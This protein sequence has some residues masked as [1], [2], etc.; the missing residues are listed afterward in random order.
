MPFEWHRYRLVQLLDDIIEQMEKE[1]AYRCFH[2]DGQ[3]IVLEDYLAIRPYMRERLFRLIEAD[4][5]QVGPWYVLQD[6]YLISDEANVRNMLIGLALCREWGVEP[7]MTGY[8]PDS[9]GNVSQ[10]PQILNGFSIHTAVFGRGGRDRAEINWQSED[11]S[12]VAA[13]WLAGWYHNALELPTD[14]EASRMRVQKLCQQAET[15]S[16]LDDHVGMNG[17]DHEPL[18]KNLTQALKTA[19]EVSGPDVQFVHSSLK[20]FLPILLANRERYPVVSGELAGQDGHG[21]NLLI[22]TASS[23]IYL[24]QWNHLVQTA[25]ERRAEPL[26]ALAS[27]YG[28]ACDR[29]FLRYAWKKLLENHAHDSICGCSVDA[30]HRQMVARFESAGQL[31][32][33][34]AQEALSHLTARVDTREV[35]GYP[36]TVWNTAVFATDGV[37]EAVVDVPEGAMGD[38]RLLDAEGQEIPCTLIWEPHTFTYTLPQDA[39]RVV[40]YVDRCRVRFAARQVP[41]MGCALYTLVPGA[42]AEAETL[43]YTDNQM[44]NRWLRVQIG[45]DGALSVTD[46]TTGITMDGL[47]VYEDTPDVGD[48][49]MFAAGGAPVTTAGV[50]AQVTFVGAT[51]GEAAFCIRQQLTV[52]AGYNRKAGH[53]LED[54]RVVTLCT[55]VSIT[56]VSRSVEIRTEIDNTAGNHR[57]CAL[58]PNSIRTDK[59]YANGQFDIVERNIHTGPQ[60]KNPTN[61][62]RMQAF[63]ELRDERQA[64]VVAGQALHE[65]EV[66]RDGSNTLSLTILRAVDELGDWGV[67]PTPEAQC[68]GTC[69]AEYTV[70]VGAAA[71]HCR[72]EREALTYYSGPLFAAQVPAGQTG[73]LR[74]GVGLLAV[75]GEGIWSTAFKCAETGDGLVLRLYNTQSCAAE[76]TLT[77]DERVTGVYAANL[78]EETAGED[79]LAEGRATL[80]FRPKEIR[81]VVLT[82]KA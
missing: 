19:N 42:P 36:L 63:V 38:Y 62:Q 78:A 59:V 43:C 74:P 70:Q 73:D 75:D 25:L 14:A 49:Y 47:N 27:L 39:F 10:I 28:K 1:P 57:L 54:P 76:A 64:L 22:G 79:L 18:Q 65:Y 3:M 26:T 5:I 29:D 11:G 71:E 60:W 2:L 80:T 56:A 58:F 13:L 6:E 24:K 40:T 81:T 32:E 16:C 34:V 45:A 67:F 4:R 66:S 77:V 50:P 21:L 52:P 23:R 37:V 7:V 35:E 20:T 31:A 33:K 69:V 48:E 46:K 61:E 53:M 41:A 55:R 12:S 82:V 72:M 30:V 17:S 44:E 51:A 9:F 68:I 15:F 8:F